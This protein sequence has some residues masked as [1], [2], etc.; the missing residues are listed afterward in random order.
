MGANYAVRCLATVYLFLL[1]LIGWIGAWLLQ[2]VVITFTYPFWT[3]EQRADCCALIFRIANFLSLDALNPFWKSTIL[4]PFPNVQGKKVLVVMNHLSG[5]DPF[6]MV[7]VLL[8]RDAA[9]VAKN[10]LFRVPFG[11]W[12]M[13]NGDDL[14]V[15]FKNKKAGLETV[16]GTVAPMMEA[17]RA[18]IHRGRMLAVFPEGARNDTPENG[19]KPFRPGFFTLAKEEGATIVPIAISGTDDCWPKHSFLMD[20]GHAYFS[21]GDPIATN[22]FNTVEELVDYVWNAVTDL[23]STHPSTKENSHKDR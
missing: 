5:A 14:C 15:Q 3:S 19:L 12:A 1:M 18:K 23:R 10:D 8:P 4:R 16:K 11:G 6:L 2:L 20:V 13:A 7:R 17:A 21:C 22:N 9:W